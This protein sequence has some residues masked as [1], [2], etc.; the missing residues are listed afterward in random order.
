MTKARRR[1][2]PSL[3]AAAAALALAAASPFFG[4]PTITV[5]E[6]SGTPPTPG[7]VLQVVATHHTDEE[8]PQVSA[9]AEGMRAGKRVTQPIVL[10]ASSRKGTFGVTKQWEAGQP[11]VLV[12]TIVQGDHGDHGTA[13]ALVK[14]DARGRVV[15][16]ESLKDPLK[17][18]YRAPR[19]ATEAEI[20]AALTSL[21]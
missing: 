18:G 2:A 4:P 6:V 19:K 12:F 11:W 9:R 21:Q 1:L 13:E 7:A 17:D 20:V 14:V 10:T 15:S 3:L 8:K 5:T 16:A